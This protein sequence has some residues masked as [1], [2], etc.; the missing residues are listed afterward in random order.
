MYNLSTSQGDVVKVTNHV[1]FSL[2]QQEADES[3]EAELEA[4]NRIRALLERGVPLQWTEV[5]FLFFIIN[6]QYCV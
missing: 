2:R 5:A 4:A 6:M 3:D 1:Q